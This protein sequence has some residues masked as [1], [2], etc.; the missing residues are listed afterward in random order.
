MTPSA[1]LMP[2]AAPESLPASRR[3]GR[4][5]AFEGETVKVALF[6]P[7]ELAGI[8]KA[9]AAREQSTPSLMVAG[10]IQKAEVR[11]A[12]ARG[13]QAFADGDVIDHEEALRRL[14][15]WG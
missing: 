3:G 8:L 9:L 10:W 4:P 12:I 15:K 14:S 13:R 5:K 1:D 11:E 6:L 7:P 2:E